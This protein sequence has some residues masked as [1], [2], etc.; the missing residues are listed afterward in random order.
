[1][2]FKDYYRVLGVDRR[3]GADE[4]QKAYRKLA[5]KYHP[6]VSKELDAET[7]F[8]EIAEAYEV[9]KD[10]EK[11]SKYDRFGQ[12]WKARE[13][14]AQPPPGF[15][16]FR[17]DLGGAP[18]GGGASGFS[19][20]FEM[21]FGQAAAD[22]ANGGWASWGASEG[23]GGWARPGANH[24]YGLRLS[25]EEAARGGVRELAISDPHGGEPRRIRINL[26]RGVRSG[27]TVRVPGRGGTGRGAG[28]TGDLLLRIEH[29]PHPRFRLDGR[30]LSLTLEVTPW[31]AA[32][33]A[34]A[35]VPTLDQPVRIR[36][37]AGT[38]SG[39][40]IRVRGRGF[41]AGKGEAA[42]DLL[43]EVRVVVPETLT[44]RERQLF[45]SLRD[46]SAF[47]PRTRGSRA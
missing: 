47:Q 5:R 19:N 2:D 14:G 45:E 40:R 41:P 38:S 25:L 12:A 36:I 28:P 37:P 22:A 4:I 18:F 24:E 23:R 43:A 33:G 10:D 11:R 26:P 31:E 29:E 16:E 30:D 32:L 3:A 1:L 20:F 42:G 13:S 34:E 44:D 27:Q 7:R 6:D 21:L 8:K 35:D 39:R 15:E 46:A 9:L 17:F